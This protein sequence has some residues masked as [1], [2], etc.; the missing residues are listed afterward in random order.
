MYQYVLT[1]ADGEQIQV[2]QC[3]Q[4]G[5]FLYVIYPTN[6]KLATVAQT[7]GDED[8]N[9]RVVLT[10]NGERIDEFC[11]FRNLISVI[12]AQNGSYLI[13]LRGSI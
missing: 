6:D 10:K 3:G 2:D 5:A 8:R 12:D 11:G 7:F 4:T 9:T 1:F 13:T